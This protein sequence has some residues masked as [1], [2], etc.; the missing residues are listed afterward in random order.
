MCS[1]SLCYFC[2]ERDLPGDPSSALQ[3]VVTVARDLL[4]VHSPAKNGL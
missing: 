1:P 4:L 3:R 2:A